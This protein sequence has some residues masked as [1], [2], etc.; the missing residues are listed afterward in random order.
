MQ[1]YF[2]VCLLLHYIAK[3]SLQKGDILFPIVL[4]TYLHLLT[5]EISKG[6]AWRYLHL[7]TNMDCHISSRES[8]PPLNI[9][10]NK[11]QQTKDIIKNVLTLC[12]FFCK[13]LLFKYIE[14]P[15]AW[16]HMN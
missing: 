15:S 13:M 16:N 12:N 10:V 3:S 4:L 11:I 7:L 2:E 8:K 14:A 5:P 9:T 1:T 6:Y